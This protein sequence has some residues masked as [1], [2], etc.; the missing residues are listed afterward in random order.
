MGSRRRRVARVFADAF[1]ALL[2][3][4]DLAD[5]DGTP[6]GGDGAWTVLERPALSASPCGEN[7]WALVPL[8]DAV[9]AEAAKEAE[10]AANDP[11]G[12]D[13]AGDS[14]GERLPGGPGGGSARAAA[15]GGVDSPLDAHAW[16]MFDAT[17][18]IM[19]ALANPS[20]SGGGVGLNRTA[21]GSDR[22]PDRF[23]GGRSRGD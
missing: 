20:G 2:E 18:R 14:G 1:D 23:P 19:E 4:G 8:V 16:R 9:A 21:S 10:R 11:A 7:L 17:W 12:D 5:G 13:S 3:P 6:E 15:S 22:A